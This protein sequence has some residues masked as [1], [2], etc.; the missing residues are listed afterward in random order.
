MSHRSIISLYFRLWRS[1]SVKTYFLSRW[2]LA[3]VIGISLFGAG[4]TGC[5]GGG[6]GEK[7]S[8][9]AQVSGFN[10]IIEGQVIKGPIASAMVQAFR[11]DESGIISEQSIAQTLTDAEGNYRLELGA[12]QGAL[13]I[14]A[15]TRVGTTM[16]DEATGRTLTPPVNFRLRA[17]ALIEPPI[18][19][20]NASQ[21]MR[22]TQIITVSP[23]SE[24]VTVVASALGEGRFQRSHILGSIAA[25]KDAIGFD[26]IATRAVDATRASAAYVTPDSRMYG[27]ALAAV[28]WLASY[29]DVNDD[30][31]R[32]CLRTADGDSA[33]RIA[34]AG[35]LISNLLEVDA[36]RESVGPKRVA[37]A[38]TDA[39][40]QAEQ[41]PE[42]NKTGM[43]LS[44]APAMLRLEG[45]A[46]AGTSKAVPLNNNSGGMSGL[47]AAKKLLE[48][49]RS[50]ADAINI[51]MT[52]EGTTAALSNLGRSL[53]QAGN[54]AMDV[55]TLIDMINGA[56]VH[57]NEYRVGRRSSA[58]FNNLPVPNYGNTAYYVDF[59]KLAT[60]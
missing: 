13:Q 35:Q 40:R 32:T 4:L 60:R 20:A 36:T 18:G 53:D 21:D 16:R 57:W 3:L 43:T 1:S 12:F 31:M 2:G 26:P 52:E 11:I 58:N 33:K 38:F 41:N 59:P 22:Q 29:G 14:V 55:G 30:Q 17:V 46:T 28:S 5:G 7:T 42:L 6:S 49:L 10:S 48:S 25:V 19:K 51:G 54:M 23:F 9:S 24:L 34:C 56:V 47:T 15:S 45:D 8:A 39:V 44:L 27:L 50:N 37:L